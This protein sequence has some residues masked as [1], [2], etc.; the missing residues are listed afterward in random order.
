M[1]AAAL[2]LLA[3][4]AVAQAELDLRVPREAQPPLEIA[5]APAHT[6]VFQTKISRPSIRD[7]LREYRVRVRNDGIAVHKRFTIGR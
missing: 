2:L 3:L 1:R 5:A 4:P 6:P 7:H